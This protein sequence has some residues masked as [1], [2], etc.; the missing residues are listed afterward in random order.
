MPDKL[1][2]FKTHLLMKFWIVGLIF[3]GIIIIGKI[4][5]KVHIYKIEKL[6]ASNKAKLLLKKGL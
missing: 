5:D 3:L 2:Y 4:A 1:L 6:K